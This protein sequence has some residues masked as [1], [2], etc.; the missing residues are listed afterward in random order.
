[1][2]CLTD[3]FLNKKYYLLKQTSSTPQV[4]QFKLNKKVSKTQKLN[5]HHN[6]QDI[7]RIIYF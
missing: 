1:M 2:V 3:F 4:K 5:I 7:K 6:L